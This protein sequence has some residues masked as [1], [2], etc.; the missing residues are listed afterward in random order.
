LSVAKS[1]DPKKLVMNDN[2]PM[3]DKAGRNVP[4]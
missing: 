2:R 1:R 3:K 4:M